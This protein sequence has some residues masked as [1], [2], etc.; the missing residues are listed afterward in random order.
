MMPRV[1]VRVPQGSRRQPSPCWA[2]A[3]TTKL[4][5]TC[6]VSN[7][8]CSPGENSHPP[9]DP[10]NQAH[11]HTRSNEPTFLDTACP[12]MSAPHS[13]TARTDPGGHQPHYRQNRHSFTSST[14]SFSSKTARLASQLEFRALAQ[15]VEKKQRARYPL[16][17]FD[18]ASDSVYP[19]NR[20]SRYHQYTRFL[21][22]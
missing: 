11:P 2:S 1:A 13:V 3:P 5:V 20:F 19:V 14:E 21:P 15:R 8:A 6:T 22:Q 4:P 12:F 17:W 9:L 10:P 18:R 7:L 16:F